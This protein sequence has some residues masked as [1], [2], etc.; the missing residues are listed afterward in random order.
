[1]ELFQWG[2]NPWG[3][4]T[5]VRISWDL[6]YL[7][8]WAGIAFILFHIAYAVVW[9]PR[10]ARASASA[11]ADAGGS[12]TDVPARIVRHTSAA[13][14]FHWVMAAAMIALLITGF[15]PI[16]GIQFPWVTI[17]WISGVLLTIS[18]LYH[19]VHATFFLDFWSIWILPADLQEAWQRV[20]HQM[21]Q[22]TPAIRKHGKYP[23]DHKLYH[24]A[25]TVAGL[26]VIGT[27]LVMMLRIDGA[28]WP[29]NPYFLSDATWGL[30][31]V[32]HGLGSVL[33]VTLTL[34][35]IYFA[36]RPEKLWITKSMIFGYVDRDRYLEHHDPQR[37]VVP[38]D[39]TEG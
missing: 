6:L 11:G 19:I 10:L 13:R 30:M 29:R 5:L 26:A 32:L 37:W 3:Q 33:F 25:V 23:L 20:R 8:F 2:S 7:A 1:M 27:G 15:F 4:E 34:T 31:Y 35:H 16:V 18:I 22:E 14:F 36:I 17:H 12:A 9:L 38:R 21:G 24:L 28:L 39:S